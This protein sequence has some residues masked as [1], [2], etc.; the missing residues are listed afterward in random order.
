MRA[1]H[2]KPPISMRSVILTVTALGLCA[3]PDALAQTDVEELGRVHG[4]ARPPAAYYE[5]LRRDPTAFQFSESNGWVQRGRQ[6]AMQRQAARAAATTEAAFAP[7]ANFNGAGIMRGELNVPVF[8]ILYQN[9]D[10]AFIEANLSRFG[11][12]Q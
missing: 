8:L 3:V 7:R 10:S 6:L 9:T 4:G 12:S 1:Q 2:P 11:A 5:M